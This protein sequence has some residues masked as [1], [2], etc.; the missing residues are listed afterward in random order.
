MMFELTDELLVI[1][2]RIVGG[3]VYSVN[4]DPKY[5]IYNVT[6]KRDRCSEQE[7]KKISRELVEDVMAGRTNLDGLR[8]E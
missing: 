3:K 1:F 2:E 5:R 6:F 4:Y 8:K 7:E